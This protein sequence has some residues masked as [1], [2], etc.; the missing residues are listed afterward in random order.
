MPGPLAIPDLRAPCPGCGHLAEPTGGPLNFCPRCGLDLRE[1]ARRAPPADPLVGRVIAD[2]Y[3]LVSLLGEGGMGAV[4]RAEHVQMGKALA[5]KVLR[6]DFARDPSAAERFRAE[7]RIVSRLSHPH[8]IAVFDFGELPERGFYLAMEYVPGQDLARALRE[9]GALSEARAVGIAQQVLGSLAEAH[10]SGVVHRDMKPAN[11]MLM[12]ARP[13]ED[14][15][16]VLDFGIAKLRDEA[17]GATTGAGAVVGTP[18]CLAPEQARGGPVD[19]R[20]DLYAMGCLLYELVSGRPPFTAASPVAVITAHLHDAPPP[21]R[22]VAPGVSRRLAEVVHRALRKDPAE[23]FPSADA[24]RDA[25]AGPGHAARPS[26]RPALPRAAGELELASREDFRDGLEQGALERQVGVLRPPRL[27]TPARAALAIAA[28]LAAGAAWRWDDL[29][30]A[31]AAAAP[32]IATQVPAALRPDAAAWVER[33]P[34][35]GAAEATPLPLLPRADGVPAAEVRG[36]IGAPRRPDEGDLD[37]YR[38]VVPDGAGGRVLR[39]RWH[40]AGAAPDQGIPGLAVTLS[41]NR[42]PAGAERAPL[43]AAAG[44]GGP[45][46]AEALSAEVEPGTYWL[47]VRERHAAGAA[48]AARPEAPYALEVELAPRAASEAAGEGDGPHK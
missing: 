13:G 5:V 44:E 29:Y 33:E 42:A 35:D 12:Q 46:A 31:L 18:S 45:G 38:L 15:A 47:S 8:T 23:R 9:G 39:A 11:V 25:L 40:A 4:Y 26:R 48:P 6:G 37:V 41:L 7:A 27:V 30:A 3:R 14:F 21:L 34:N 1:T 28:A 32:A 22:E 24:M 20:A 43:V 36:A 19:A 16:K 17:G 10:E 2:R